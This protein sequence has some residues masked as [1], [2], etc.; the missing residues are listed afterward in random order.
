MFLE[1]CHQF[2]F[3]TRE[4]LR[5]PPGD[6]L[7]RF[8]RG[9][10][11]FIRS[12]LI[13]SMKPQIGKPLLYRTTVKD[14]WDTI[15]KLY[16]KRHNASH[17]YTRRKQVHDCKQGTLDVTSYFNKNS[18][19]W[20][21]MDL[22]TETIWDTSNDGIQYAKLEEANQIYDFFACLNPKVTLFVVV[23]LDKDLFPP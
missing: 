3:L 7:E 14:L 9:E 23:Y 11:S 16:L 22:W 20:Q 5:L 2:G 8:W 21:E 10:D 17:L 13:N 19:L 15:H 18:L 12:M 1:G 4:A 6:D